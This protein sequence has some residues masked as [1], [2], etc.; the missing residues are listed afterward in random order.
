MIS[1]NDFKCLCCL[2]YAREA[3]ESLCCG[4]ILCAQCA[5]ALNK[6][7][8]CRNSPMRT[9][10]SVL[11]RRIIASLP[12]DCPFCAHKTSVSEL[13]KHLE[14][15]PKRVVLCDELGCDFEGVVPEFF[16]H[17]AAVHLETLLDEF[18]ESKPIAHSL[19]PR[20]I[21]TN[22]GRKKASN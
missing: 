20:A 4:I 1:D 7:P 5:P 22:R 17:I 12:V 13:D 14:F 3:V 11:A 8:G 18:D 9:Q 6:C 10:T 2:D 19:H 21:R 15:C 16:E